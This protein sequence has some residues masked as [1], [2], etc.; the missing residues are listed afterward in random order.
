M[1]RCAANGDFTMKHFKIL[2]FVL[3]FSAGSLGAQ[4][5]PKW[6]TADLHQFIANTQ[7][8]VIINFWASWCKPCLEELPY[9]QKL[10]AQYASDSV[11]LVLVNLDMAEHYPKK[12]KATASRFKLKAPIYFLDETDADR[13][14]PVVDPSW[15]GAIPA[16]LL[17]NNQSGYRRFFEDQLSEKEL[18]Q[19]IKKMLGR[20]P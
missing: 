15:S 16:S 6:K 10:V 3:L 13:F 19:E 18:D 20:K 4:E 17:L 7:K 5:I 11:Q 14:C 9:F 8:P 12:L 2:F 1:K